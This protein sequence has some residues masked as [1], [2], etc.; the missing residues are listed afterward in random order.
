MRKCFL[1]ETVHELNN[2]RPSQIFGGGDDE[3]G[4]KN[5]TTGQSEKMAK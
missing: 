1:E 4:G 3:S 2:D 5:V